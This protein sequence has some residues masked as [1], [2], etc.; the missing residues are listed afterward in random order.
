M[1]DEELS[2]WLV[3]CGELVTIITRILRECSGMCVDYSL[4]YL[5]LLTSLEFKRLCSYVEGRFGKCYDV[6]YEVC[7]KDLASNL[8]K[9]LR[10]SEVLIKGVYVSVD[11]LLELTTR[12]PELYVCGSRSVFELHRS[13]SSRSS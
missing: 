13:Y 3:N 1:L 8:S 12:L 11:E 7:G 2:S 9:L 6:I 10:I 4:R 5:L